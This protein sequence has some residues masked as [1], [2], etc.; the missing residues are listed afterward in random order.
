MKFDYS[1]LGGARVSG[2]GD[3]VTQSRT[4]AATFNRPAIRVIRKD[5]FGATPKPAR[6]TRALPRP[7]QRR[8]SSHAFAG[9]FAAI[10]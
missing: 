6:A 10:E 7:C 2:V 8:L 3:C 9:S 1:V 5:C 4:F